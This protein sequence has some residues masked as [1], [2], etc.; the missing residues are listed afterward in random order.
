MG[1]RMGLSIEVMGLELTDWHSAD[2]LPISDSFFSANRS[3]IV[4]EPY[5]IL[6]LN[7]NMC[8]GILRI[9][10]MWDT[11]VQ[12]TEKNNRSKLKISHLFLQQFTCT[13]NSLSQPLLLPLNSNLV[14]IFQL[15]ILHCQFGLHL[16]GF[17]L[18]G[19]PFLRTENSNTAF[20]IVW[21]SLWFRRI[22]YLSDI[23]QLFPCL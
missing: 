2:D 15:L 13:K 20:L 10:T 17:Y 4:P 16:V 21:L 5:I 23:C 3:R 1:N 12:Y 7:I 6:T 19:L 9:G 14:S 18:L 22:P 8:L 11:G